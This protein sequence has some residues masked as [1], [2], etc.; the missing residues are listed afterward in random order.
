MHPIDTAYN[1]GKEA[2][3]ADIARN[4][5]EHLKAAPK[6]AVNVAKSGLEH[7]KNVP[8]TALE[9]TSENTPLLGSILGAGAGG[10]IGYAGSDG[11]ALGTLGGAVAGGLAG[12]SGGHVVSKRFGRG[13]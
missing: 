2:A 10:A 1:M 6:G 5:L 8:I 9:M 13:L 11:D 3:I 7:L 4:V 12:M